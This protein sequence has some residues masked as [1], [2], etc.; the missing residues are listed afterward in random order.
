[1][2]FPE[3]DPEVYRSWLYEEW[4]DI[5]LADLTKLLLYVREH[6]I[7]GLAVGEIRTASFAPFGGPDMFNRKASLLL[8][9]I[10]AHQSRWKA[11]I[12]DEEFDKQYKL[13]GLHRP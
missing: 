8:A 5:I 9:E 10:E 1:M 2:K 12:D 3:T 13:S 6:A 7:V 11:P 4:H